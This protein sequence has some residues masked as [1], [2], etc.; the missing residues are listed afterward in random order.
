MSKDFKDPHRVPPSS[1]SNSDEGA[2]QVEVVKESDYITKLYG[3]KKE[4]QKSVKV[5][6]DT[7]DKAVL[8]I[9]TYLIVIAL[10]AFAEFHFVLENQTAEQ[11]FNLIDRLWTK[12]FPALMFCLGYFTKRGK[13]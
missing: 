8:L 3:S 5:E 2:E 9:I 11:L 10:L 12:M 1:M 4:V 13:E 6:R 7:M